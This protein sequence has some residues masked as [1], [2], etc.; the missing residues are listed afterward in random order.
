[1]LL[2]AIQ[3]NR[4]YTG[5]YPNILVYVETEKFGHRVNGNKLC[6]FGNTRNLFYK[7]SKFW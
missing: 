6:Q 2:T 3:N 4:V 5:P 1:M 7:E